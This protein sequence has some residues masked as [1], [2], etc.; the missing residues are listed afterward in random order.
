MDLT[1]VTGAITG[2]LGDVK[3]IALTVFGVLAG[4]WGIRKIVKMINKS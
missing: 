3:T 4:I 2:A 1:A